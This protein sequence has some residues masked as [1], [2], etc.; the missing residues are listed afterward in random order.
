[1][2]LKDNSDMFDNVNIPLTSMVGVDACMWELDVML[3]H[4]HWSQSTR[5]TPPYCTLLL[6][7][8][9]HAHTGADGWRSE[10]HGI[11]YYYSHVQDIL[12]F[13]DIYYGI[14]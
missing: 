10:G 2:V 12:L 5:G 6:L 9:Q 14:L 4:T 1:M 8:P 3:V 11:S 13:I 7:N